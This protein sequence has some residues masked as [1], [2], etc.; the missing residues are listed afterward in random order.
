MRG[1][2]A[3]GA[4]KVD[5]NRLWQESRNQRSCKAKG[6]KDWDRKAPGFARRNRGSAYIEQL[7][8]LIDPAQEDT[9]LD[10]G[11]GPGTLAIPLAGRVKKVTALDFSGQMLGELERAAFAE[12]L[13]NIT[14]VQAAWEDDW[15]ALELEPHDIAVASRSMSVDDLAAALAKINAWARKKV[16]ISDR[17]GSGPFDPDVFAAVGRP[18]EPGPDYIFTVNILHQMGIYAEVEMIRA[19]YS[20]VYSTREEAVESCLWMLD[21]LQPSEREGFERFLN[22]RLQHL[23]GGEWRLERRHVPKW[24]VISWDKQD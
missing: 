12:G 3:G 5:W 10:V 21:G 18:F 24:A 11:S 20:A 22:E 9:V 4:H 6:R 19:E 16:I 17:V 7:L 8:Q 14:T 13:R 15:H 23:P 1:V 2:M